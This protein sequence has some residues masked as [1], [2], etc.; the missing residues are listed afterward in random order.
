MG[1]HVLAKNSRVGDKALVYIDNTIK[2][3]SFSQEHNR[4]SK[5]KTNLFLFSVN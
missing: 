4:L 3:E 2:A 5:R 1:W